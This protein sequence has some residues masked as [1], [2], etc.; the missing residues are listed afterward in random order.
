MT[1]QTFINNEIWMLTF[2]AA[3]QRA[4][5][6]SGGSEEDKKEFRI[7]LRTFIDNEVL[8][9]YSIKVEDNEH[10]KSIYSIIESS[11]QFKHILN[12]GEINFGISQKILNL[13]LK[14]RWCIGDIQ[15]PPHFPVD[16]RIQE[17]IK[18]KKLFSWTQQ[19]DS[20]NY[21]ELINHV[22]NEV[23]KSNQYDSIAE[24]ELIHFG[25]KVN[26]KK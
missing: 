17:N 7:H 22:R 24:Y 13:Y 10:L 8:P 15:T 6:Y 5:I 14:Y 4:Y 3:F 11:K 26:E 20:E 16:R 18:Y 25:R 23:E 2:S 21:M 9:K 19:N 12:N 1:K